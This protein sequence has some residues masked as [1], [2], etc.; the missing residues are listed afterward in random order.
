MSDMQC[1][2]LRVLGNN[3]K[4]AATRAHAVEHV[5]VTSQALTIARDLHAEDD[6][7]YE[8]FTDLTQQCATGA[9]KKYE[10]YVEP[11]IHRWQVTLRFSPAEIKSGKV[12][13]PRDCDET[14][15]SEW[16]GKR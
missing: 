12:I 11:H 4:R 10:Q 15:I 7:A 5:L 1:E 8:A 9:L 13:V 14:D 6:N 16:L 2:T 3:L